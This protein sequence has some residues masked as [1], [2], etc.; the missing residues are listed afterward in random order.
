DMGI[1]LF[2]GNTLP[3]CCTSF[4]NLVNPDRNTVCI[5]WIISLHCHLISETRLRGNDRIISTVNKQYPETLTLFRA[6]CQKH[7]ISFYRLACGFRGLPAKA[8]LCNFS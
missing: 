4:V 7:P 3:K 1:F 8:L 6:D 5:D 2:H